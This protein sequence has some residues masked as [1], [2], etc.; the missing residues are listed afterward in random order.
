MDQSTTHSLTQPIS[1]SSDQPINKS[2]HQL[3]IQMKK[4]VTAD[5]IRG[6]LS[7]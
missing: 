1:Q 7:T 4:T 2:D 6:T 3:N 5:G